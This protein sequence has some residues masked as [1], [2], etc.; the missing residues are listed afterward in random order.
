M[1][2]PW[3]G[4]SEYLGRRNRRKFDLL[5]KRKDVLT[6][7][8]FRLLTGPNILARKSHLICS[9]RR[10]VRPL[11]ACL[12]CQARLR[13]AKGYHGDL[14]GVF[15]LSSLLLTCC[16]NRAECRARDATWHTTLNEGPEG[17]VMFKLNLEAIEDDFANGDVE[18]THTAHDNQ[19]FSFC[20]DFVCHFICIASS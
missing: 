8:L 15:C 20:N 10:P 16:T 9:R 2:G 13:V 18:H 3:Q 17:Y 4:R 7:K 12:A 1:Q 11:M 5:M 19:Q 14:K 6:A